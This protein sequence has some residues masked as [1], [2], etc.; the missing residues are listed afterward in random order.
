LNVHICVV[1]VRFGPS[2]DGVPSGIE[3]TIEASFGNS[4]TARNA[5]Q[6]PSCSF[7][8]A[9]STIATSWRSR[10]FAF[11]SSAIFLSSASSIRRI[12]TAW[13]FAVTVIFESTACASIF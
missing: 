13:P 4:F 6:R 1:F 11:L 3:T 9:A 7:F 10:G 12:A 8:L 2:A 5:I